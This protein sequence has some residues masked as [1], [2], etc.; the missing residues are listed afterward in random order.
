[1]TAPYRVAQVGRNSADLAGVISAGRRD[2]GD[3]GIYLCDYPGDLGWGC[4]NELSRISQDCLERLTIKRDPR[5]IGYG[6][7]E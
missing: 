3:G 6:I 1:M 2:L 5:V 4:S 7:D